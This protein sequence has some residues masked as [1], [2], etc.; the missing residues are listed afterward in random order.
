MLCSSWARAA[1]IGLLFAGAARA[2]EPPPATEPTPSTPAVVEAESRALEGFHQTTLR[3]SDQHHVP[4]DP[5]ELPMSSESET[6][7]VIGLTT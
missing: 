3:P 1:A 5:A 4:P 6:V 7:I 2:E